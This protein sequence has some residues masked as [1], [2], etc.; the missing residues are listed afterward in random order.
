MSG[1]KRYSELKRTLPITGK[2]LTGRLRMLEGENLILR[3]M[4]PEIPMRVEYA[5]TE[6]GE[7]MR[8]MVEAFERWF[9]QYIDCH[10]MD[11]A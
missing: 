3:H 6:K 4:Y 2:I 11:D 7:A 10:R 8:Q 9:S 1:P 5:L